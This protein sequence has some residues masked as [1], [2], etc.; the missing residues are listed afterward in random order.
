VL[1]GARC[2]YRMQKV[3]KESPSGHHRTTLS[4]SIF[5]TKA[6]ID[7]WKNAVKQQYLLHIFSQYRE[8]RPTSGCD[9][10][11]S[12]GHP[13]KF[14]RVSCLG[15]VIA[16]HSRIGRQPNF[17]TLNRGRHLYS[18]GRPSRWALTHI[19]ALPF[20]LL[21]FSSHNLSDR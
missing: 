4:C 1:H 10:S 2:K 12:L 18:A 11:G 17:A 3:V 6:H 13:C 19:L 16:R 7:N 20:F 8:L 9:R 14:K 15:S 5:A 21:L